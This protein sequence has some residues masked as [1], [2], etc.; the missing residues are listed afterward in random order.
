MNSGALILGILICALLPATRSRTPRL[1]G[2]EGRFRRKVG[3]SIK[4]PTSNRRRID[5]KSV[6]GLRS[7]H[8]DLS[9][10]RAT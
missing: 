2:S 9:E 1:A 6:H 4:Q 7:R 5:R 10:G 3:E 8:C